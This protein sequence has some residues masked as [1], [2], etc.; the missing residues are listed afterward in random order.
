[1]EGRG[2]GGELYLT[3]GDLYLTLRCHHAT[4]RLILH[5]DG[6]DVSH[7]NASLTVEGQSVH[8]PQLVKRQER[9]SGIEPT[10][11]RLGQKH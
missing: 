1:M 11:G 6:H 3:Q 7:S 9:R 10:S 8:A 4:T 5:S 2:G